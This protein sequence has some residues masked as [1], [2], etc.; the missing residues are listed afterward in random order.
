MLAYDLRCMQATSPLVLFVVHVCTMLTPTAQ[1][2]KLS[3]TNLT[4]GCCWQSATVGGGPIS[5]CQVL[6]HFLCLHRFPKHVVPI[7]TSTVIEC[8]RAGLKKTALEHAMT[9]MRP[10]YRYE[11]QQA[12]NLAWQGLAQEWGL[13][14]GFSDPLVAPGVFWEQE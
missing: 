3:V 2:L 12:S 9:L 13:L 5:H 7:L 11:L 6:L 1:H 8:Q 14:L 4:L 10:E